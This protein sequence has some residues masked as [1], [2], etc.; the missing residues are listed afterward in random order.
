MLVDQSYKSL[1]M[2]YKQFIALTLLGSPPHFFSFHSHLH[3]ENE[4]PFRDLCILRFFTIQKYS[5]KIHV[6][7]GFL[8]IL[9]YIYHTFFRL[10][11][12]TTASNLEVLW[13]D[14]VVSI[15]LEYQ[16]NI[17]QSYKNGLVNPFQIY[18]G[19]TSP[20]SFCGF[21]LSHVSLFLVSLFFFFAFFDRLSIFYYLIFLLIWKL[22]LFI[23]FLQR[24]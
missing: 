5:T 13:P 14:G 11:I 24:L 18:L 23:L 7:P 12:R 16:S 19:L 15:L 8:D 1:Q 3:I 21:S 2:A 6:F 10:T 17:I 22:Y 9:Q 20:F 4:I